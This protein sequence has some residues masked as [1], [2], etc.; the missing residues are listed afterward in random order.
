MKVFYL[1]TF[2][3]FFIFTVYFAYFSILFCKYFSFHLVFIHFYLRFF[4]KLQLIFIQSH[5]VLF[6]YK[7]LSRKL[8]SFR[9]LKDYWKSSRDKR[10]LKGFGDGNPIEICASPQL[11]I[12]QF[13]W[14]CS[15]KVYRNVKFWVQIK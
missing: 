11:K 6:Y 1:S 2:P 4:A 7:Y 13:I 9:I 5:F 8:Q 15:L 12:F 14:I 10:I 3:P